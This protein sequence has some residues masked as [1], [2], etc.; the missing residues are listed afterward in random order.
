MR[1]TL[2]FFLLIAA[3]ISI[4]TTTMAQKAKERFAAKEYK[5]AEGNQLL[6]R[7][8]KPQDYDPKKSYPLVVFWH[9]AGE[10]GDN[11]TSQLVHGM[12]DFAT[13]EMMAKYPA[14]V[15]APQCPTGE[16]WVNVS[17][18]ADSHQMEEK[19]SESMR[20]SFELIDALQKEFSIDA[21]RIYACGLS[22]GGFGTW[23]ALQR[24]PNQF[25]AA[26]PI[27]GGGDT[28]EAAEL[29]NTPIWAFHG[30]ADTVVKTQRSR[31]MIEAIKAAGG[32]P[33]YTEYPN[34][35]HNSWAQ[36]FANPEVYDWLFAQHRE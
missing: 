20:M 5:D 23:D 14:F 18:A 13:D 2:P 24:R 30:G 28:A 33:K 4:P 21:N 22:M 8:L 31:D 10:R 15:I 17:W 16:R 32:K 7:I 1:R 11:N 3:M 34:V 35:G 12:D 19:P 6:Y 9:G 25:A 29:V 26:I 27:C 36:T